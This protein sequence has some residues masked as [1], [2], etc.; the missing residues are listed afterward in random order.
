MTTAHAALL[1]A[2]AHLAP[3]IGIDQL[4]VA[5]R[6]AQAAPHATAQ[7]AEF[8]AQAVATGAGAS[9]V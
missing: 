9:R 1:S 2:L 6:L 5:G 8:L 3:A 7:L 4:A